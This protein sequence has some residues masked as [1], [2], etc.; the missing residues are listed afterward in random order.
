MDRDDYKGTFQD[1]LGLGDS[2]L[3]LYN[4]DAIYGSNAWIF[5]LF[6]IFFILIGL[7]LIYT[8][9]LYVKHQEYCKH[10]THQVL[11]PKGEISESIVTVSESDHEQEDKFLEKLLRGGG[12]LGKLFFCLQF[13][14][15][16]RLN[17][18]ILRA[19]GLLCKG[20]ISSFMTFVEIEVLPRGV[21]RKKPRR[22]RKVFGINPLYHQILD[23]KIPLLAL[24]QIGFKFTVWETMNKSKEKMPLA[25]AYYVFNQQMAVDHMSQGATIRRHLRSPTQAICIMCEVKV[26]RVNNILTVMVGR[27]QLLY[28]SQNP[29]LFIRLITVI[30]RKAAIEKSGPF[31]CLFPDEKVDYNCN[32]E[33]SYGKMAQAIEFNRCTLFIEAVASRTATTLDE[34]LLVEVA[35]SKLT[36][37]LNSELIGIKWND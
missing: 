19:V 36:P 11:N 22:S 37:C 26:R 30:H 10:M 16:S 35:L 3:D 4:M 5:V 12:Q 25:I 15:K 28:A 9:I 18:T 34:L 31:V 21:I 27:L 13:D 14:G 2:P 6:I 32:F 24:D 1:S 8:Y 20:N 23:Y 29:K 17:L 33:F 7:F